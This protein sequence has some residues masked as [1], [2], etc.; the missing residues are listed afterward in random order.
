MSDSNYGWT[1]ETPES[2]GYINPTI[3]RLAKTTGARTAL[4]AGCGNGVLADLL[5]RN[6]LTVRG[7]DADRG[8]VEIASHNYPGVAF[9]VGPSRISRA[10]RWIWWFRPKWS[11]T[12][13][14]RTNSAAFASGH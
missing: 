6:G 14:P 10:N 11:N 1:D 9:S 7:F 5:H 4:D 8:G 2:T 12:C 13:M 3:L